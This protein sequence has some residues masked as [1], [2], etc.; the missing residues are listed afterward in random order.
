M[1]YSVLDF[2]E[3]H[4]QWS[5]KLCCI[6]QHLMHKYCTNDKKYI[7]RFIVED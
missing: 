4:V 1:L 6:V 5:S 2:I 7:D 3:D